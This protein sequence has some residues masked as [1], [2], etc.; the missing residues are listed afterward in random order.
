MRPT[1]ETHHAFF[2]V[3]RGVPLK[4][5]VAAVDSRPNVSSRDFWFDVFFPRKR[6]SCIAE[7]NNTSQIGN[8]SQ[9]SNTKTT[10]KRVI[11][12]LTMKHLQ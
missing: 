9:H 1:K 7:H 2:L 12:R 5:L 8:E 3:T 10:N 4:R 6:H 11:A